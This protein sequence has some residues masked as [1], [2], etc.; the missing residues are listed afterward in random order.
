[1]FSVKV[2]RPTVY[3]WFFFRAS[4]NAAP[5]VPPR[6]LPTENYEDMQITKHAGGACDD[7]GMVET[8]PDVGIGILLSV[9]AF[10][11]G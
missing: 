9:I 8:S 4:P 10:R 7:N 3:T 6:G 11:R 1:M 2:Y 5:P